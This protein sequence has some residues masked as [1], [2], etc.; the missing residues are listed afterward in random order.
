MTIM[1][2]DLAKTHRCGARAL[3][4]VI[5]VMLGLTLIAATESGQAGTGNILPIPPHKPSLVQSVSVSET[6]KSEIQSDLD[7]AAT[8]LGMIEPA[9]YHPDDAMI[10]PEPDVA[11][12][13]NFGTPIENP[14][15]PLAKP[16]VKQDEKALPILASLSQKLSRPTTPPKANPPKADGP[17]LRET[18]APV[19][20]LGNR[21]ADL[22]RTIFTAQSNGDFAAADK[23]L[24]ELSDTQLMGHVLFQRYMHHDYKTNFSELKIWMDH[25]ADHPGA[26]R[27]YKL[28][29]AR[30]PGGE[31]LARPQNSIGIGAGTLHVANA[32]QTYKTTQKRNPNQNAAVARLTA[33]V[34]NDIRQGA[35]T[36]ALRRFNSDSATQLMDAVEQD[37]L[38]ARIAN[39]YVLMGKP[40]EAKT[41]AESA[42]RRSGSKAPMAGWAGGLAAWQA[43]DYK[44]AAWFFE[45]TAQSPYVNVWLKSGA[46]YWAS[47]SHMRAGNVKQVSHW[48]KESARHPRTFY[49]MIATRALGRDFDF[50]WSTPQLTRAQENRLRTIPAAARAM[51][52]VQAGQNHLAEREMLMVPAGSDDDLKEAVLA[53]TARAQLPALSMRLANNMTRQDGSLYDGALYPVLPWTPS[54]TLNVD[55]ALL[56]AII[57]Q[58]S[59]FD[60]R[61]ESH[62]GAAGLMQVMPATADYIAGDRSFKSAR[63]RH[64]LKDPTLNI[65]LGQKYIRHLLDQSGVGNDLLSMAIAY[66]AGPGNLRKWKRDLPQAAEDPLLFI[67]LIPMAETRTYVE[68]VLANYWIYALRMD[69]PVPT[70]DAVAAGKWAH[71]QPMDN[72]ATTRLTQVL[73]PFRVASSE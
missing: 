47:R 6:P 29:Q 40:L 22:Y 32:G 44:Q 55:Q 41:L 14:P 49:G 34:N 58:E 30:Q 67:E 52:L 59:K 16:I 8:A 56:H 11:A 9:G 2:S 38:K 73:K 64:D 60:V 24:A 57:R 63:D 10:A 5:A 33:A 31:K 61:A 66:N 43:K 1:R 4:A 21:D 23:A 7:A 19:Q 27:I 72:K 17:T 42:V 20:P 50:D 48:L 18:N 51:A 70:L 36:R 54:E 39:G 35:P 65:E 62:R 12:L 68:R 13:L 46:A 71:Y 45:H 3:Q 28:A 26:D 69:Q 15:V 53:Y 25:Y 37:Q